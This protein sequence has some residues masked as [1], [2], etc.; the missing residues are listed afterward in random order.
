MQVP[1][2]PP[3]PVALSA[4]AASVASSANCANSIPRGQAGCLGP[5]V[6]RASQ[7]ASQ[8]CCPSGA[9]ELF[10]HHHHLRLRKFS[11]KPVRSSVPRKPKCLFSSPQAPLL[12]CSLSSFSSAFSSANPPRP[13]QRCP[14]QLG[15][16]V[17]NTSVSANL[18]ASVMPYLK[19][20]L[21]SRW[22][23]FRSPLCRF[24]AVGQFLAGQGI[25]TGQA[26][27]LASPLPC[28]S[29]SAAFGPSSA[30]AQSASR[31]FKSCLGFV[32]GVAERQPRVLPDPVFRAPFPPPPPIRPR[33][34]SRKQSASS[35]PR[36]RPL[37]SGQTSSASLSASQI[38]SPA[39]LRP[40]PSQ[41]RHPCLSIRL[42]T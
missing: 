27:S 34:S 37:H 5:S 29:A 35:L 39:S 25:L 1:L 32:S 12:P 10:H 40:N 24:H 11:R 31:R 15:F 21:Q 7:S 14:F 9:Q 42:Q 6:G 13:R 36:S 28:F 19:L 2:P 30:A 41:L 17:A 3:L 38:L 8:K 20:A 33:K 26:G 18:P 16:N 4:S 23:Q 22:S